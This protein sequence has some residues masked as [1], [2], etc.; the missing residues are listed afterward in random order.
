MI[1]KFQ[2][3]VQPKMTPPSKKIGSLATNTFDL[4]NI[5]F[6]IV[7]NKVA[8]VLAFQ[9]NTIKQLHQIRYDRAKNNPIYIS[10]CDK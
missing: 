8:R 7:G 3:G 10:Q 5:Q 1:Y 2:L 6:S 9:D 4:N